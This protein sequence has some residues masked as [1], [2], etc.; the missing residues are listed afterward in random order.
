MRVASW[1]IINFMV[2]IF[3]VAYVPA[4]GILA[5]ADQRKHVAKTQAKPRAVSPRG[6]LDNEEKRHVEVFKRLSPSVVHINTVTR[7]LN[8][9]TANITEI[10]R[11]SGT[12]FIWDDAGHIVTNFHVVADSNRIVV[13]LSD[14][15]EWPARPVGGFADRDL[16]VLKIDAPV[17]KLKPIPLGTSRGLQVG[18]RVY[19]IGNPF[20]LDQTMT[21]GVVSALDREIPGSNNRTL[22]GVIQTDAAINPGNSG[23]PMLDSAGLLIG[24]NT[25]IFSPSGAS[26]G[27]GFAIPADEI[28]RIIPRLIND[29]RFIR[30]A[31]GIEGAPVRLLESLGLKP[32]VPVISVTR[33]GPADQAGLRPFRRISQGRIVLGDVVVGIDQFD[34]RTLD[35]LYA[36]LEQYLPGDSVEVRIRR[37]D[38][39]LTLKMQ[40]ARGD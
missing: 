2:A 30:P 39:I 28:N 31:L 6:A 24:V 19:A 9:F 26:A 33:N 13:T 1:P 7:R 11:G 4:D 37:I 25:A 12:G 8:P 36:A 34:V 38:E 23:G 27:I 20:G 3:C 5:A 35:D 22:R 29:G 18:Q 14:Q 15:T 40:L 17:E 21:I 16:F 10:P 32:G